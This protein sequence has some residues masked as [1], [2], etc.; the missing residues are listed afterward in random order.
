MAKR[1]EH[2]FQLAQ[3]WIVWLESRKYYERRGVK[4]ILA[5]LQ[6]CS[7]DPEFVADGPLSSEISA[8]N[9]AIN[10][11]DRERLL[12][13][14]VIYCGV[15]PKPINFLASEYGVSRYQFYNIAHDIALEIYCKTQKILTSRVS[16]A[17]LSE[18]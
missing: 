16:S 2:I 9:T 1:H 3:D 8:F 12:P 7:G 10:H 4:C 11:I 18:T 6:P 14:I 15:R 5:K 13:F 17:K